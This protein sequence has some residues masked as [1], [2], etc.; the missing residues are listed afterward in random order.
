MRGVSN[1]AASPIGSGNSVVPSATTPCKIFEIATPRL[2]FM[3]RLWRFIK[4]VLNVRV[5]KRRVQSQNA[6]PHPFWLLRAHAEPE[7]VYFFREPRRIGKD[8]VV[9]GFRIQF[10]VSQYEH[11]SRATESADIREE[12]EMVERDLERLHP[13]HRK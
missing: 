3:V 13:S 6:C 2:P 4:D 11:P 10:P 8:S 1:V 7:Q 9:V 5:L 12:I